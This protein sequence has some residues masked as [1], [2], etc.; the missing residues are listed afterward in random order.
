MIERY[1][2]PGRPRWSVR[3]PRRRPGA[4]P[5]A[6]VC[7]SPVKVRAVIDDPA[8]TRA[9]AAVGYVSPSRPWLDLVGDLAQ[10]SAQMRRRGMAASNADELS[11]AQVDF[12]D[13]RV[14]GPLVSTMPALDGG[15]QEIERQ[16]RRVLRAALAALR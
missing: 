4:E 6:A 8:V 16:V 10:R 3:R 11:I 5:P 1:C 12:D 13:P 9:L 7:L 2:E 15:R 14:L